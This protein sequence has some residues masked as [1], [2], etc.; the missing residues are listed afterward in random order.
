MQCSSLY[1][2]FQ[3]LKHPSPSI[4]AA[5]IIP[6][7][8]LIAVGTYISH[9]HGRESSCGE[10]LASV[11]CR[12]CQRR[13]PPPRPPEGALVL[14]TVQRR[15]QSFRKP[16]K[17]QAPPV[18]V[19]QNPDKSCHL[20]TPPP[21]SGA[22]STARRI[23]GELTSC[24]GV[25]VIAIHSLLSFRSTFAAWSPIMLSA[26]LAPTSTAGTEIP[27]SPGQL[28]ELDPEVQYDPAEKV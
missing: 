17:P 26:T 24:I 1:P 12:C 20:A 15:D 27:S 22:R 10:W 7:V 5:L 21:A 18:V 28:E 14:I 2:C 11:L 4:S 3:D 9:L 8:L 16:R 23:R 13:P 19:V 25:S 6:A